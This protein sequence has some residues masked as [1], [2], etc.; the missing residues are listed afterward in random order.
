[1]L[2]IQLDKQK[3]STYVL[4]A[5]INDL[6]IIQFIRNNID[7]ELIVHSVDEYD[8][9][10]IVKESEKSKTYA[11][12]LSIFKDRQKQN[13]ELDENCD[14]DQNQNNVIREIF[15]KHKPDIIK[16]SVMWLLLAYIIIKPLIPSN[17]NLLTTGPVNSKIEVNEKTQVEILTDKLNKNNIENALKKEKRKKLLDDLKNLDSK[18]QETD[19]NNSLILENINLITK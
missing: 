17:A 13:T 15:L 14:S 16:Y 18:I 10:V 9:K 3:A 12:P 4:E 7:N 19:K 6:D 2:T 5:Q 8:S 11:L 1:M